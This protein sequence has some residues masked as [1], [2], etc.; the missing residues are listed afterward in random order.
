MD[1]LEA[2]EIK[3]REVLCMRERERKRGGGA[4]GRE[5]RE[6]MIGLFLALF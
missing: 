3:M 1:P 5:M 4:R 6:M 2:E